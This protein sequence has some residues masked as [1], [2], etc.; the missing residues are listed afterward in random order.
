MDVLRKGE[1]RLHSVERI[2]DRR[3]A[4]DEEVGRGRSRRVRDRKRVEAHGQ[5]RRFREISRDRPRPRPGSRDLVGHRPGFSI[6]V[7][8]RNRRIARLERERT[9]PFGDRMGVP[10]IADDRKVQRLR[11]RDPDSDDQCRGDDHEGSRT[12]TPG[13][14]AHDI[15]LLGKGPENS[16]IL[17]ASS[18]LPKQREIRIPAVSPQ[19]IVV[20]GMRAASVMV[21]RDGRG[22][23]DR[24]ISGQR[25]SGRLSAASKRLRESTLR[26]DRRDSPGPRGVGS[27]ARRVSPRGRR[28]RDRATSRGP[29]RR[30]RRRSAPGSARSSGR[31]ADR[32]RDRRREG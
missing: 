9:R 24:G 11:R 3:V 18:A 29:R 26:Q 31:R 22:Q 20:R 4:D 32:S 10:Q 30:P 23:V 13:G 19:G 7:V 25:K 28:R 17:S 5:S 6:R 8:D 15:L 21:L 27:A 14:H 2:G 16:V 1:V 12:T